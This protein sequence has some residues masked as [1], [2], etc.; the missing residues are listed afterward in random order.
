[1]FLHEALNHQISK[2]EIL[3]KLKAFLRK[4]KDFRKA[5]RLVGDFALI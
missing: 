1:M 2:I 3:I 5:L 4:K